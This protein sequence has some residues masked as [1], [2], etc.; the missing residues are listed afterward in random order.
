MTDPQPKFPAACRHFLARLDELA[1]DSSRSDD[2]VGRCGG[3]ALR[4]SSARRQIR[5]LRQM[6]R[7]ALPDGFSDAA[8]LERIYERAADGLALDLGEPLREGLTGVRAPADVAWFDEGERRDLEIPL[9]RV[10]TH[11]RSPGWMWRRIRETVHPESPRS[12][13]RVAA[14][15]ALVAA[16]LLVGALIFLPTRL[17]RNASQGTYPVL[18]VVDESSPLDPSYSFSGLAEV[19]R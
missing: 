13:P 15:L 16:A 14:R 17:W 10:L 18:V 6:A 7:P 19:T 4:L 5:A 2:H 9:R 11:T 1:N 8:M 12:F 3:C